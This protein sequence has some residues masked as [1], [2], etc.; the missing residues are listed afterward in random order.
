MTK[1]R[2]LTFEFEEV[3]L[4]EKEPR[5]IKDRIPIPSTKKTKRRKNG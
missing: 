3:L 2:R 1:I 4:F 5:E